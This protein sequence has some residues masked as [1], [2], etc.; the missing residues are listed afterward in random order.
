MGVPVKQGPPRTKTKIRISLA[1]EGKIGHSGLEGLKSWM[2]HQRIDLCALS[3]GAWPGK[4]GPQNFHGP[5]AQ[6]TA[7]AAFISPT[8]DSLI[9]GRKVT[10]GGTAEWSTATLALDSNTAI[11]AAYITPQAT[12]ETRAEFYKEITKSVILRYEKAI[13]MGDFNAASGSSAGREMHQLFENSQF[14][15]ITPIGLQTH[16]VNRTGHSSDID[17]AFARGRGIQMRVA[18]VHKPRNGHARLIFELNLGEPTRVHVRKQQIDWKQ[19]RTDNEKA[20]NYSESVTENMLAGM[21]ITTAIVKAGIR[22]LGYRNKDESLKL[23][24]RYREK[25]RRLKRRIALTPLD[26]ETH[27]MLIKELRSML[28]THRNRGWKRKLARLDKTAS[29]TKEAWDTIRLLTKLLPVADNVGKQDCDIAREFQAIYTSNKVSRPEWESWR[30]Q[31]IP[32]AKTSLDD[33]FSAEE[34]QAAILSFPNGKAAGPSGI[35]YE[36]FKALAENSV[37]LGDMCARFNLAL[38]GNTAMIKKT[39]VTMVGIPKGLAKLRPLV[40]MEAERKILERCCLNRLQ[41]IIATDI[42]ES[43]SGFRTGM[44]TMRSLFTVQVA[45][46]DS[47]S[48]KRFIEVRTHDC[49]RAFDRVPKSYIGQKMWELVAP[50]GPKLARLCAETCAAPMTARIGEET[51]HPITG[52]GQGGVLSPLAF[53]TCVNEIDLILKGTGYKLQHGKE[54]TCVQFA[55]D[56]TTLS[57]STDEAQRASATATVAI[58]YWGG[59]LNPDKTE[60]LSTN[61]PPNHTIKMLGVRIG[62]TGIVGEFAEDEFTRDTAWLRAFTKAQGLNPLQT[63]R[64]ARGK[65]W[66]KYGYAVA[67]KTPNPRK[68]IK[69]WAKTQR[70]C[71]NTYKDCH[72]VLTVRDCGILNNAVWFTIQATITFYRSILNDNHLSELLNYAR[73]HNLPLITDT[74]EALKPAGTTL[75]DIINARTTNE[76]LKNAKIKFIAWSRI[77]MQKEAERLGIWDNTLRWEMP[78]GAQ[79]YLRNRFA[80][81]GFLFRLPHLGIP[82]TIAGKCWFCN[83]EN[84]DTGEHLV[85]ECPMVPTAR[86]ATLQRTWPLNDQQDRA[87]L[88]AAL[89]WMRQIWKARKAKRAAADDPPQ[90]PRP[91]PAEPSTF[92]ETRT[93]NRRRRR[94]EEPATRNV[95]RRT[96]VTTQRRTRNTPTA[97]ENRTADTS[98]PPDTTATDTTTITVP[99]VARRTDAERTDAAATADTTTLDAATTDAANTNAA[100]PEAETPD[101][102]TTDAANANAVTPDSKTLDAETPS[103]ETT[104][105]TITNAAITNA[106]T[107]DAE[108]PDAE[109]PDT[110]TTDT[111]I[112]NTTTPDTEATKAAMTIEA[113]PS[114]PATRTTRKRTRELASPLTPL[115]VEIVDLNRPTPPRRK[116]TEQ[117]QIGTRAPQARWTDE[118]DDLLIQAL[119]TN[120]RCWVASE[121]LVPNRNQVHIRK[122]VATKTFQDRVI[123]HDQEL[124]KTL[125]DAADPAPPLPPQ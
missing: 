85:L 94:E 43:Q 1:N 92:F 44:S 37:V 111:A 61:S 122:R 14:R 97:T 66:T 82:H 104:D 96:Q 88:G 40:L 76:A 16:F 8:T 32:R 123:R 86:P 102:E 90:Q 39:M 64:I 41:P 114:T 25:M 38:E 103:A 49:E 110:E 26:T 112:I 4:K 91:P 69:A 70:I 29:P 54:L 115:R 72:T 36:S 117:A 22:T 87:H 53:L 34:V 107:P 121:A 99:A 27:S 42:A 46:S 56:L 50:H 68:L 67:L 51:I 60:H 62:K 116:R 118:E 19:L 106:A 119:K 58:D 124:Y 81:Y 79:K 48:S 20:T 6:K 73:A 95:R 35:T 57:E 109:T 105:A 11:T 47:I 84:G 100:T 113:T 30:S 80:K 13:I 125:Y 98:P 33:W 24:R 71:L 120:G 15:R 3:E 7:G 83:L 78:L 45:I 12:L 18:A 2:H 59:V 108:T 9:T 31:P 93:L 10:L 65:I 17:V 63:L 21:D 101:T 52:I 75:E 74:N 28:A 5:L 55:D 77:Q 23:P 89:E